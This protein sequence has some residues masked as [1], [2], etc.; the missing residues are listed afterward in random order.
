M[1]LDSRMA[2]L[3]R[4]T[5][6]WRIF[7][8][9][10]RHRWLTLGREQPRYVD[11]FCT[12]VHMLN[13]FMKRYTHPLSPRREPIN[14]E[15]GPGPSTTA[16]RARKR[17]F[18]AFSDD[19]EGPSAGPS[20]KRSFHLETYHDDSPDDED[21]SDEEEV[22]VDEE[23]EAAL[24]SRK[25][26]LY[27][28][29]QRFL[30]NPNGIIC[31]PFPGC[32]KAFWR[33]NIQALMNHIGHRHYTSSFKSN[34][35]AG[36]CPLCPIKGLKKMSRECSSYSVQLRHIVADHLGLLWLC[37]CGE[38]GSRADN[39]YLRHK[40]HVRISPCFIITAVEIALQFR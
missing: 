17:G 15:A 3:H 36:P 13:S 23:A 32:R 4:R 11:I 33:T 5:K 40:P 7:I 2:G 38:Y 8:Q 18:D 26:I 1:S 27:S 19:S 12:S 37:P 10:S 39:F 22:G 9:S 29:I 24:K 30:V 14:A 25:V 16:Y 34:G 21:H 28:R 6:S 35:N 20:R 31:C